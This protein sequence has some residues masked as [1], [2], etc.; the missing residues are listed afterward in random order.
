MGL[1]PLHADQKPNF[2]VD[3]HNSLFLLSRLL[4]QPHPKPA[5]GLLS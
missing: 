1:C 5:N 3:P 2:L 4:Y